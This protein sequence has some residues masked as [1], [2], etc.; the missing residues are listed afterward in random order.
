MEEQRW[1]NAEE[2]MKRTNECLEQRVAKLATAIGKE[3]SF[4]FG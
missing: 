1:D 2:E 3:M 4:T